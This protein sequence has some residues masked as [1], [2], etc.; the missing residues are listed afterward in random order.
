[1]SAKHKLNSANFLGALLI[2]GLVGGGASSWAVFWIALAG[3]LVAD[4]IAGN[5]RR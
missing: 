5:I 3:V 2:A 4:V 1:M